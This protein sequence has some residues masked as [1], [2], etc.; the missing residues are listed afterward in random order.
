MLLELNLTHPTR[1]PVQ[2]T[3]PV[4]NYQYESR[5]TFLTLTDEVL[6]MHATIPQNMQQSVSIV[7]LIDPR[8]KK[9]ELFLMITAKFF[10]QDCVFQCGLGNPEQVQRFV[11]N[12]KST[13]LDT[14]LININSRLINI[15]S[16]HSNF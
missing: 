12:V 2:L 3:Q 16:Y 7:V 8:S 4:L 15:K 13:R 6:L 10:Y 9:L 1:I 5:S 11:P 14:N